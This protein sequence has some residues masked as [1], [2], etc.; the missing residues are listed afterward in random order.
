M[1]LSPLTLH[2]GA[3]FLALVSLEECSLA[4]CF[5]RWVGSLVL[6]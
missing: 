4:D 1:L 6:L 3:L 5:S 2:A